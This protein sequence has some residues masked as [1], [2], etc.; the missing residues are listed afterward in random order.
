MIAHDLRREI[1]RMMRE[2][3][4][5][6]QI[7]AFLVARYTEFVLYQPT[8]EP[9]NWLLWFGPGLLVLVGAVVIWRIVRAQRLARGPGDA[10][11][12]AETTRDRAIEDKEE[13]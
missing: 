10:A 9:R 5:D 11:T 3:K 2:G 4:T 12:T 13:W 6:A 1:L 8:V 7:E